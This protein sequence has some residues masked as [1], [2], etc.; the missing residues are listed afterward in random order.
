MQDRHRRR[1]LP[2]P[3]RVPGGPLPPWGGPRPRL[4]HERGYSMLCLILYY[5]RVMLYDIML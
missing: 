3:L 4:P 2:G 5:S 1:G